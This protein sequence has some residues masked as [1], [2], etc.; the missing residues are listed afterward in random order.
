M[1]PDDRTPFRR[2][3]PLLSVSLVNKVA[4]VGVSLLPVI[5]V[6]R[7]LPPGE[8]AFVLGAARAASV[9]GTLG[10]G[11]LADRFGAKVALL[12][13]FALA[14]LGV[15]GMAAPGGPGAL[16]ATAGLAN[17]GLAM[18]PVASRLLLAAAVP[19]EEQKEAVAWLRTV[20]NL[21]LAVSFTTSGLLGGERLVPL[22]LLDAAM[23][24]AALVLGAAWLPGAHRS[25]AAGVA[26]RGGRAVV[27]V[28]MTALV[29]AWN[30]AYEAYLASCAAL[31]RTELGPDGVRVFSLVMI[32][33]TVGCTVLGVATTRWI[34]RPDR[35]VPAGFALLLLGAVI[36][37]G[38]DATGAL[39]G[40]TFAT[41]GELLWAATAQYVW[42]GLLPDGARRSTVFAVAMTVTYLARALGAA[43]VFPLVVEGPMPRLAMGALVL[44]GLLGSLA[45][46]PIWAEFRRVGA[47][48]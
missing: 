22:L 43:A 46:G 6:E 25:A 19:G 13:S 27:F 45:A 47:V 28:A 32:A 24:L 11:A 39:V 3:L 37:T 17:A 30:G 2:A 20:A 8:A 34:A 42:M 14:S 40:V 21:G 18:F 12:V 31:L 16:V 36:G 10:S 41:V 5:V 7:G 29:S 23:S 4:S 9:V 38:G 33:N 15:A 1:T 26:G 35:S 44:P 48:R